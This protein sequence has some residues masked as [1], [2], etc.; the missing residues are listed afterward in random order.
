[1]IAGDAETAGEPL[2]APAVAAEPVAPSPKPGRL[3][4]AVFPWGDVWIDGKLRGRAPVR[5]VTLAPGR[6]K[7]SAGQGEPWKTRVVR[8][9]EGQRLKVQFDLSE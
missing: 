8:L 4:V 6:H 5:N 2:A 1:V 9:K 7:V 3:S